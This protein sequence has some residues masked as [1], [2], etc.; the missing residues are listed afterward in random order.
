MSM[1]PML[2]AHKK[3]KS[4]YT[5]LLLGRGGSHART[6]SHT[7]TRTHTH[8][9]TYTR[10]HTHTLTHTHTRSHTL[11]HTHTHTLHTAKLFISIYN[12]FCTH[13]TSGSLSLSLCQLQATHPS[14]YTHRQPSDRFDRSVKSSEN[15]LSLCGGLKPFCLAC[16]RKTPLVRELI[17]HHPPLRLVISPEIIVMASWT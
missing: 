4:I 16:A 3:K 12:P 1:L 7:H 2:M 13:S 17:L 5:F 14:V 11:A 10:T 15:W 9:H 8:I 6:R